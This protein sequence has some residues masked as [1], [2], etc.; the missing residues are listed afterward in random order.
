MYYG[1]HGIQGGYR[2]FYVEVK[3]GYAEFWWQAIANVFDFIIMFRA[4]KAILEIFNKILGPIFSKSPRGKN[5]HSPFY[6]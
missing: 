1:T 5:P 2:Q 6:A 3:E 4:V